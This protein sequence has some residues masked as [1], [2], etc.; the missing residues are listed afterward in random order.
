M[1]YLGFSGA[2]DDKHRRKKPQLQA[3]ESRIRNPRESGAGVQGA[4]TSHCI[5]QAEEKRRREFGHCLVTRV[6]SEMLEGSVI[7]S[8]EN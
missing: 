6:R 5:C 1:G 2:G 8:L 4:G 3:S 7:R